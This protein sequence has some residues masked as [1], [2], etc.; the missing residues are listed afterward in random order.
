MQFHDEIIAEVPIKQV[1]ECAQLIKLSMEKAIPEFRQI[2]FPVKLSAGVNWGSLTE[3][4]F[5]NSVFKH[6]NF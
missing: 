6:V 5:K 4:Y 1:N 2:K 3:N